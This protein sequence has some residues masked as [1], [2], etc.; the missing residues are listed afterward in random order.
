V[1]LVRV[2]AQ[3]MG[4]EAVLVQMPFN[5]L[6]DALEYG[7]VDIVMSGMTITPERSV[8]VAMVGPYYT[9][10]KALLTKSESLAA[11]QIPEDLNSSRFQFA[12]LKGS[13]SEA[14]ARRSLPEARLKTPELLEEGIQLVLDDEVDALV[15]DK[16]TG[17][18]A[19]LRYPDAGL[20]ASQSTFTVEPM[21]I[22]VPQDQPHLANLLQ[23]YLT[24]LANAGT[25]EKVR[26]FWFKD[27]SWVKDLR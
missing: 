14:F 3:A 8:R 4:V 2:L 12:A 22:A 20:H 13:T 25:L 1:A 11:M 9:S 27:P 23:S 10:G 18:F 17:H 16:E 26:A 24:S 5:E 7:K 19:A 15:A 21:G 6:L